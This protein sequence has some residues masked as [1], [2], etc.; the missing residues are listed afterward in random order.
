M[1]IARES[2]FSSSIRSL[3]IAF[4]SVIGFF[5][6]LIPVSLAFGFLLSSAGEEP[7]NIEII[8]PDSGGKRALVAS[9]TPIILRIDIKGIIGAGEVTGEKIQSYLNESRIGLFRNDQV[10]GIL[11]YMSSPGGYAVP[12][13]TI[14]RHLLDYK[15]KYNIPIY[16]FVD[17]ECA[18]GGMY[19]A[20]ATDKIYA[21]DM[22]IIGSVGVALFPF[23]NVSD[24]LT[25][26]GIETMTVTAGKQKDAMNPLRPWLPNESDGFRVITDYYYNRF[27]DIVVKGRP[28]L[29]KEELINDY[30]A[31]IF[32]APKATELGY[33]DDYGYSMTEVLNKL[34]GDAGI[35]EQQ[36]YQV[37]QFKTKHKLT[38]LFKIQSPMITGKLKHSL[39]LNAGMNE[40]I[41]NEALYIRS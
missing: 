19:I 31:K 3:C 22:S 23:F 7:S 37:V 25:K 12:A 14:Y 17:G 11:L 36:H 13:D 8:E 28:K 40:G 15:K 39:N 16:T 24:A 1:K 6:A 32:T 41:L 4:F 35:N 21:T 18:S 29:S 2:I 26:L 33:I 9:N 38:D 30:G 34:A 5:I 20:A 27:V 10:K